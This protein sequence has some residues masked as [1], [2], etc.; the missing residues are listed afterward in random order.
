MVCKL[1]VHQANHG[2]PKW[3]IT[4]H[5]GCC[6]G[7]YWTYTVYNEISLIHFAFNVYIV[8]CTMWFKGKQ[9]WIWFPLSSLVIFLCILYLFCACFKNTHYRDMEQKWGKIWGFK[10]IRRSSDLYCH[11]TIMSIWQVCSTALDSYELSPAPSSSWKTLNSTLQDITFLLLCCNNKYFL[12]N[13]RWVNSIQLSQ[14][15]W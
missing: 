14:G 2:V 8:L 7:Y 5:K 11:A 4:V 13:S 15:T 3:T 6:Y 1:I 12:R 10:H 9:Q